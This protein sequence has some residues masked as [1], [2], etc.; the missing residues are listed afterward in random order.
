MNDRFAPESEAFRDSD[1]LMLVIPI[2]ELVSGQM[3]SGALHGTS[4]KLMEPRLIRPC[5]VSA[6]FANASNEP[7]RTRGKLATI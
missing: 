6:L 2:T 4:R 5:G 3:G 7:Y 1:H